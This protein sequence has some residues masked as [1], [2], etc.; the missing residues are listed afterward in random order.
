[1]GSHPPSDKG[2]LPPIPA[3]RSSIISGTGDGAGVNTNAGDLNASMT[4]TSANMESA[5]AGAHMVH[6]LGRA[7]KSMSITVAGI[8]LNDTS[9]GAPQITGAELSNDRNPVRLYMVQLSA[10]CRAVWLYLLQV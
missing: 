8:T 5:G 10:P 3:P 1:M 6:H 7:H 9:A 2:Q 4:N